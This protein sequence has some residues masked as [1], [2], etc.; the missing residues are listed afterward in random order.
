MRFHV[1]PWAPDYGASLEADA[2]A[3]DE[4]ERTDA[5][6]EV[7]VDK[8][9]PI[10]PRY[11]PAGCAV[12]V[13]GVQRIDARVWPAEGEAAGHMAMCVSYAAG[14]VRCDSVAQVERFEV[15]RGAFGPPSLGDIDCGGAVCYAAA[16]VVEQTQAALESHV[17]RKREDL[18]VA[19]AR[20]A[21]PADLV[22]IDGHVRDRES[23][24]HA[25]GYIKTHHARYLAPET[26]AVVGRLAAGERTPLFLIDAGWPRYSWYLRLPGVDGYPWAGVVRCEVSPYIKVAEAAQ[27]ADFVSAT[28]PR[29]ASSA[30]KDPRAPQNLY[31]VGGLERE[32]RRRMGEQQLLYRALLKASNR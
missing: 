12:F 21:G 2:E 3:E 31:P 9:A 14:A 27:F 17:R 1:E 22:V 11:N 6:V 8:W 5:G 15:R 16:P 30:H 26:A 18:E 28:L 23:I 20:A 24:D 19:V 25:V 7:P 10:T 4:S 13:D 29:F 32:L